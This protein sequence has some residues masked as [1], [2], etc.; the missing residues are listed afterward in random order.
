VAIP[1]LLDTELYLDDPHPIFRELRAADPVFWQEDPGFYAVTRHADVMRVLKDHETFSSADGT[2]I[3]SMPADA[4]RSILHMDPPRHALVRKLLS[5]E[6]SPRN[7]VDLEP[8]IRIVAARLLDAVPVGEPFDFAADVADA[9]PMYIVGRL[10]GIDESDDERFKAWNQAMIVAPPYSPETQAITGEIVEYFS[11]LRTLRLADPRDDLVTRL[12][13]A[14]VDARPLDDT[15]FFGNLQT[16][17]TAGQDTTSNLIS[18]G[19]RELAAQPESWD[20]VQGDPGL[21]PT[22]IEEMARYHLSVTFMARRAL[23]DAQIGD[24]YVEK[25]SRVALFFVSANRDELVFDSPDRFDIR[26]A[27]NPHLTFGHGRHFCIGAPLARLETQL[28][29]E[30]LIERFSR[31]D[32]LGVD[33]MRSTIFPGIQHM[34][35]IAHDAH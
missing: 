27:P 16:L 30:A 32:V 7:L 29:F 10:V 14:R 23:A 21:L 25:G 4:I 20:A 31:I 1:D 9:L 5:V 15:E 28:L 13:Y 33:R 8:T 11:R 3:D 34:T 19:L 26:R 6:F 18:G 24:A 17:M 2:S 35:T 22:A 12:A